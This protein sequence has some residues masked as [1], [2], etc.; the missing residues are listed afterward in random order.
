MIVKNPGST[1]TSTA[2]FDVGLPKS[3]P[4]QSRFQNGGMGA[5]EADER[6]ADE[7]GA[8]GYPKWAVSTLVGQKCFLALNRFSNAWL[9]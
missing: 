4:W 1:T 7:A 3:L 8:A 9:A 2:K 6:G 5:I